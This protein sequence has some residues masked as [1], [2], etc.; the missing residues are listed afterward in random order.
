MKISNNILLTIIV[1]NYNHSKYLC[2]LIKEIYLQNF[3]LIEIIIIDDC[4]TDNSIE[5]IESLCKKYKEIRFLRNSKN[6]GVIF[7]ANLGA[8]LAKGEYIYFAAADDLILKGFFLE[9]IEMFIKY[10]EAGLC[11]G[12]SET[13]NEFGQKKSINPDLPSCKASYFPPYI[14]RELLAKK[15]TWMRG[16]ST[17]FRKDA[18][19]DSGRLNE[20]AGP[21]SDILVEM[22]IAVKYGVCFI[23]KLFSYQRLIE[24][25]YSAVIANDTD[26]LIEYY[27]STF[28][29]MKNNYSDIFEIRFIEYWLSREVL[30]CKLS[31]FKKSINN[32]L[33]CIS[34]FISNK[35][36]VM[37]L[38]ILISLIPLFL[39]VICLILFLN[40]REFFDIL[41]KLIKSNIVKFS[42]KF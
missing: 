25:S 39:I 28:L 27:K 35:S 37:I 24:G 15:G 1:P 20:A 22:I 7:T 16:T 3:K 38:I 33:N 10:P 17:I 29:I 19:L 32:L 42:D 30:F 8:S 21:V 13:L 6:Q 4:S 2:N 11:S 12:L 34:R 23:P 26:R 41:K 36:I 14:C 18:F 5:V 40:H 31:A 9:S